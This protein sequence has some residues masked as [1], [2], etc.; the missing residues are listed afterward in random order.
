MKDEYVIFFSHS[1]NDK[2]IGDFFYQLLLKRGVF[3]SEMF[4][5]SRDDDVDSNV[6]TTPLST[7]IKN[8]IVKNN[9]LLFYIIGHAYKKSEF[10]MFEGGAGWATRAI[11][12]YPI[13]AVKY[14][15]IPKFLTNDKKEISLYNNA[16]GTIP[17]DRVN[18]QY[19]VH[20]VNVLINHINK[21]RRLRKEA[22]V[23]EFKVAEIPDKVE[24]ERVKKSE[25]DYMDSMIKDYWKCYVERVLSQYLEG[26][27]NFERDNKN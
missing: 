6:D 24:L 27:R 2:A 4:Y 3:K 1:S 23:S 25:Q 10:C 16:E 17:L 21:G 11:G 9:T 19:I 18:Y 8:C 22:L 14:E 26:L 13:V 12:D 5:T 7:Q 20:V 15:H